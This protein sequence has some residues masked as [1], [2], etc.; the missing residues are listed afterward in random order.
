MSDVTLHD[1]ALDSRAH[2]NLNSPR[3]GSLERRIGDERET[4]DWLLDNE[5]GMIVARAGTR[6][7]R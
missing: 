7:F 3:W 1:V 5:T 4:R 2:A 6:G